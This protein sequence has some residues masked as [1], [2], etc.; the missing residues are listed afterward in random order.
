[1]HILQ[2]TSFTLPLA[3]RLHVRSYMHV[4]IYHVSGSANTPNSNGSTTVV[5]EYGGKEESGLRQRWQK[6]TSDGTGGF[7]APKVADIGGIRVIR[8]SPPS[9]VAQNGRATSI[10][11]FS[12]QG[13]TLSTVAQARNTL[14]KGQT[15]DRGQNKS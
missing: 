1:M 12:L 14:A 11:I 3:T 7:R 2:V 13:K 6:K 4:V 5:L 8:T 15:P 10:H 9:G